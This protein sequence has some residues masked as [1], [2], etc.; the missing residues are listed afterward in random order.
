MDA[1]L[2]FCET[3]IEYLMNDVKPAG[4]K[5]RLKS[6]LIDLIYTLIKRKRSGNKGPKWLS[7]SEIADATLIWYI[8]LSD[9]D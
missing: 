8:R 3:E 5:P 7:R 2:T 1:R 6:I 9:R 4:N